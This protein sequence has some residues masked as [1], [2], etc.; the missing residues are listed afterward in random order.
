[1]YLGRYN[2]P[3]L[4]LTLPSAGGPAGV[5]QADQ[6]QDIWSVTGAGG[7]GSD[8]LMTGLALIPGI[9]PIASIGTAISGAISK[10]ISSIGSGR[11]EADKIVPVQNELMALVTQIIDSYPRSRSIADLQSML[12][13]LQANWK[14]FQDFVG[15]RSVF[16][17]GRAAQQALGD[18]GPYVR[19]LQGS[20]IQRITDLGG[21]TQ[22]MTLMQGPGVPSLRFPEYGIAQLPQAG[23][24][25]VGWNQPSGALS[26]GMPGGA[27]GNID[28]VPV[29]AVAGLAYV[30]FSRRKKS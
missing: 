8:F 7:S 4:G 2:R 10:A 21:G 5:W 27:F 30:I 24:L 29:L 19:S 17:D 16:P 28:I 12:A 25:P 11:K 13:I 3:G 15:N 1:M 20:L 22:P 23:S 26:A 9:G 6:S 18:V 14:K